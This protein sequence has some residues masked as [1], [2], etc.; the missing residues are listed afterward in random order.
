[1]TKSRIGTGL[2]VTAASVA[3]VFLAGSAYAEDLTLNVWSDPARLGLFEGYDAADN[4][5]SLNITTVAGSDLVAK[6]QLSLQ[7]GADVPDVIFMPRV[8]MT[9]QLSTRRSNY[10]MDLTDLVSQDLLD[11][12][13]TNAN[14]TCL[15]NGKLLCLRNDIAHNVLW[16]DKTAMRELGLS[17]PETWGEFR[18]LGAD[19]SAMGQGHFLGSS[20]EPWTL[21]AI[22]MSSGCEVA[23]PVE[24]A[25][26]TLSINLSS[27]ACVRASTL[28]DE[29]ITDGSLL[30]IGPFDPETVEKAQQNL[31]PLMIGPTWFGQHV[32]QPRYEVPAG[33]VSAAVPPRWDDQTQ[34]LT[35]GWGGGTYGMWRNTEHP[36]EAL[37][38]VVYASTDIGAQSAATTL[39][40]YRPAAEAWTEKMVEEG[41][42][43]DGQEVADA[44]LEAAEFSHPNYGPLRFRVVDA[45][46][47]VSVPRIA[48]G[49][50]FSATIEDLEAELRNI[51]KLNQYKIK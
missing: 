20:V 17:V 11:G 33:R 49:E 31:L 5:V 42:F 22:L 41:Y 1:M 3:A 7:S 50:T 25:E 26:N 48:N 34:P 12:Y 46:G 13:Y 44:L 16:Y 37:E 9:A 29:M 38:L 32:I 43:A 2:K 6:M 8:D 10:L 24:G 21:M 27:E 23:V 39:P 40:G 19:L 45:F 18:Q 36:A 30:P 14:S 15:I 51:A 4:G 28:I 35:W 47:K